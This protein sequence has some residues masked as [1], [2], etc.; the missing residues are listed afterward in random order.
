VDRSST[1]Q[2]SPWIHSG[3]ISVRYIYYRVRQCQ[4][5]WLAQGIDR[6]RQQCLITG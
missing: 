4:E 6:L 1:S 3:T 5:A 2:L